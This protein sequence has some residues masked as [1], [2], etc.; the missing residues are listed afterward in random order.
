[1]IH[2]ISLKGYITGS[3]FK[4]MYLADEDGINDLA[5]AYPV[6]LLLPIIEGFKDEIIKWASC[7]YAKV[8]DNEQDK[9]IYRRW[10]EDDSDYNKRVEERTSNIQK[11]KD[12]I[13][14]C[15][16]ELGTI[17]DKSTALLV[18]VPLTKGKDIR[19]LVNKK[20][21]RHKG[22]L[23]LE[24]NLAEAISN[25]SWGGWYASQEDYTRKAILKE[26]SVYWLTKSRL[27]INS[28]IKRHPCVMC[29]NAME[30]LNGSCA[31]G[32][33]TCSDNLSNLFKEN[34]EC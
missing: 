31:F 16:G 19:Y 28:E 5:D 9:Y 25:K 7:T 24:R 23:K 32:G 6:L 26:N 2:K 20:S 33:S 14:E 29:P 30:A 21:T 18:P 22:I 13:E 4:L 8:R 11:A 15:A 1:M 12:L 10:R 27:V 3:P 17:I 34:Q